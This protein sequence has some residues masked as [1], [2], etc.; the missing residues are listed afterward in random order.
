MH[1]DPSHLVSGIDLSLRLPQSQPPGRLIG[2]AR[3]VGRVDKGLCDG[4]RM[5]VDLISIGGKPPRI[6]RQNFRGKIRNMYPREN[7]EAGIVDHEPESSP[8]RRPSPS[9][10]LVTNPTHPRCRCPSEQGD[11]ALVKTS[12]II[13]RFADQASKP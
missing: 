6:E 2:R 9:D 10:P 5:A 7:R 11:P 4:H 8:L 1:F 3:K 12:D 13:E